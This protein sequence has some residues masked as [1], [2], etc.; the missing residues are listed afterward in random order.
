MPAQQQKAPKGG[1]KLRRSSKDKGYYDA[2][3]DRTLRNKLRRQRK[4]AAER[5]KWRLVGR[6]KNGLPV[7]HAVTEETT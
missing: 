7:R 3:F 4:R 6:K 1:R 5:D 2:G